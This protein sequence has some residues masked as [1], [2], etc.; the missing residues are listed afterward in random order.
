MKVAGWKVLLWMMIG[1]LITAVIVTVVENVSSGSENNDELQQEAAEDDIPVGVLYSKT[2]STAIV[3]KGMLN[4]A[5]MAFDEI[6]AAGGINGKKIRYIEADYSSDPSLAKVEIKK[7]IEEDHVV[8]TVGCYSSASRVATLPVLEE[9]DSLLVYPAYTEGEE[10]HPNVIYTGAMPNQQAMDYIPW[11]LEHCGKKVMLVGSNYVFPVTSNKFAKQLIDAYGGTVC[12]EEYIQP[13]DIDFE[14]VWKVID[15]EKPDYIYCDLVGDSVVSFYQQYAARGYSMEDCPIAS[16]TLDE[17]IL[18]SI[19]ESAEGSYSSMSYF[20]SLDTE[21]SKEFIK[22]YRAYTN[23]DSEITC[24]AETSYYSCYLLCEALKRQK[25][26]YD[27]TALRQAFAGL[28]LDAPQGKICVDEDN[29]CTWMYS[30][31]AQVTDGKF[32]LVYESDDIIKPEVF[33]EID[34]M[35]R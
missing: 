19:G 20:S 21:E 29:L 31:F 15:E 23:D 6:N 30:R 28:E 2:G 8:A 17:N 5:K 22:R 13:G 32:E 10:L 24:L 27:T 33:S 16:I 18:A 25:D 11:L 34:D 4:A 14:K 1:L 35:I 3:E 7:L 12:G 9:D 26:I